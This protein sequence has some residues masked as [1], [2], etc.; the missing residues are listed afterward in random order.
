MEYRNGP[1]AA[2]DQKRTPWLACAR[3]GAASGTPHSGSDEP[4]HPT[5]PSALAGGCETRV[6]LGRPAWGVLVSVGLVEATAGKRRPPDP[7][8]PKRSSTGNGPGT[9][10][11]S[12]SSRTASTSECD[13]RFSASTIE[14]TML[15]PKGQ[16]TIRLIAHP[17]SLGFSE[18][19]VARALG[20][21]STLVS[22][23]LGELR[24]ELEVL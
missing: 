7:R 23:L 6:G 14:W 22:S 16:A 13:L 3:D 5:R 10:A 18:R 24:D 19:E 12:G 21:T 4:A 2:R 8:P 20:I 11:P 1:R 17:I 15:A 9:G